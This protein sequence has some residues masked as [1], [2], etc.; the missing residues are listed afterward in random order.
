MKDMIR[1]CMATV[2]FGMLLLLFGVVASANGQQTVNS[3][4]SGYDPA[5]EVNLVGT[6]ISYMESSSTPP[7]GAHL[8]IQTASGVVDVHL[9]NARLLKAN[10]FSLA[11]GD[12]VRIVGENAPYGNGTQFLA[13]VVQKGNQTLAVR[14]TRG[15]PL[16][17]SGTLGPR[18]QGGAL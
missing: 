7:L 16:R 2:W 3:L 9:G 14:S 6:V 1:D 12:R 18:T 4:T 13:R 11:S 15:F 8:T 5:R 10:Q 17:P